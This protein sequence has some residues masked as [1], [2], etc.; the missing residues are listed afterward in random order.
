MLLGGW[1]VSRATNGTYKWVQ[2]EDPNKNPA[3]EDLNMFYMTMD[4]A[5]LNL[6]GLSGLGRGVQYHSSC[7]MHSWEQVFLYNAIIT[8]P[9]TLNVIYQETQGLEY[10]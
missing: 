1:F 9:S 4:E 7:P 10:I 6:G 5:L 8:F 2:S 3:L